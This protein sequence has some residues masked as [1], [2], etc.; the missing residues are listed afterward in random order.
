MQT[1]V[2]PEEM[3]IARVTPIFKG[4]E[5]S[6]LGNYRLISVLCCLSKILEKIMYNR[7]YKHLI[8]NNILYKKQFGFQEN[9]STDH[10]VIQLVDQISNSFEKNHFTLG[11]F[12]D[13]SKAFDTVDHVILLKKLDHY[14]VKGRNLLWLKSYLNNHRQFIRYNNS[15]MSF[16]NISCGVP[17][18][19]M[20]GPLLFLLYINVLPNAS[21]VLDPIM[22]ADDTNLFYSNNDI[23]TLFSTVNIELEE[24]SEWFKANKLSL[25]I[26][27]TN[28]TLFHKNST[29]DNLPSKSTNLKIVNS[30]LKRQTSINFLGVM[31]DENILWKEHIKTLENKLSKNIGLLCKAKQLLDNEALKSI[32]I[33]YIHSYLNYTKTSTKLKKNTLFTKNKQRR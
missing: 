29:K 28:Y 1:G 22:H 17:Q 5:E 11:V 18:G 21:P 23:E 6:D 4:G 27:K 3:K 16:A 14:A 19:S 26:K 33:S 25:N 20:L 7:L 24:I 13:L 10:A 31:L 9:H 30:V 2:F 32:Y 15:N 8:N 12:M